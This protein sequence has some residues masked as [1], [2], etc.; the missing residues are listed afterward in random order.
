MDEEIVTVLGP[1]IAVCMR[2][3]EA[4]VGGMNHFLLPE[5]KQAEGEAS[6]RYGLWAM[7]T[8]VNSLLKSGAS[9]ER[10]EVKVTGGGQIGL[11]G[12]MVS[13][14]NIAFIDRFLA[15]EGLIPKARDV[16]GP[17]PRKVFYHPISGRLVVHKLPPLTKRGIYLKEAAL[18]RL[19][20]KQPLSG[21]VEL[22]DSAGRK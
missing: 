11:Y 1:C 9:R 19:I 3:P 15:L 2:D 18:S 21:T 6:N 20:S 10:L 17:H 14:N 13:F 16:G 7:E 22:F 8:L 5:S 12:S 4:G